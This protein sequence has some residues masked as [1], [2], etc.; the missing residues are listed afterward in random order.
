MAAILKRSAIIL[1]TILFFTKAYSQDTT[2]HKFYN[3]IKNYDLS[4]LINAEDF[5]AYDA[6]DNIDKIKRAEILGFIG[7]DFQRFYIHFIS[8]IQNPANPYEYLVYGKTKVKE[9]ICPFQGKIVIKDA[10]IHQSEELP[11]FRQG[12]A[13]CE[14]LLYEDK[15]LPA[16]GFIKGTLKS[17]FLID[18]KGQFRYDAIRF[19]ADGFSNNQFMG[20]WTS[21][22][23]KIE[24]KCN[25]GDYRIPESGALDIG[26]EEFSPDGKYFD[27]GWKYYILALF[28]ETENDVE[29]GKNNEKIKWWQ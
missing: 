19:V 3:Q 2:S 22:K 23:T 21:Y 15:K 12:F 8:I 9:T 10:E 24:K 20:S 1:F 29:L 16:T 14:V 5:L 7:D 18:Q 27:K 11:A 4:A 17:N 13:T 28:G 25:W 6:E 26:A